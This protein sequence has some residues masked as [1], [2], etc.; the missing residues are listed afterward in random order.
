MFRKIL[1]A[2][3]G[4]I[5][6]RILRACQEMGV[7]AVVVYSEADA[8]ALHVR[9]AGEAVC[10]GPPPPT[11]SY[12]RADRIVEAARATGCDAIHPGYGFLAESPA[13]ARLVRDAGLV[14]VGPPVAA[15][16]KMGSKTE[17]RALMQQAGVP[18]APGFAGDAA[19]L[20]EFA[21]AAERIGYPLMVKAA[22]GGG[23]IGLRIVHQP[24]ALPDAIAAA[25]HAAERAFGD[26]AIFLE[27]YIA[28]GRHIEVQVLADQ[29]GTVVHLFE[30]DCSIQRRHQKVIEETPATT[31]ADPLRDAL[32]QAAIAAARAVGYVN[33]GT[34]EFIVPPVLSED[35]PVSYYFLEMNTRLQVEH[36]VT[37]MITGIDLVR[38]QIAIAAGDPLPFTQ[39][40]ISRRGHAVECR[41]YAEDPAQDYLPTTGHVLTLIEPSGPGIRVDSSVAAGDEISV[42][43][44]PLIAKL[45]VWAE[46][47]ALALRRMQWALGRYTILGLTTNLEFLREVIR[48]PAYQTGAATTHFLAEQMQGW[49][50]QASDL[51]DIALIAA[52]LAETTEGSQADRHGNRPAAPSLRPSSPWQRGD[53]FRIGA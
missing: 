29:H 49:Q 7:G 25:R 16:E 2:N 38:A 9:L 40:A 32:G 45:I 39:D 17:A 4:E 33:A 47:R 11:E 3:R 50:P 46:D 22:G 53:G 30:R 23:G 14:F 34:V 18:V 48:H 41:I 51:D 44:D 42:H 8:N 13:F 10:I 12:L 15:I 20:E 43:Y 6:V 36:P 1:I 28:G 19:T 31:L 21:A 24:A 26:P 35:E 27:K 37:E 5:A 52:A